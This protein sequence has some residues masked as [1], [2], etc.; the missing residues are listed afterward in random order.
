MCPL[1]KAINA[2]KNPLAALRPSGI[3]ANK[4]LPFIAVVI[5]K[6]GMMDFYQFADSLLSKE[7]T[8]T[9]SWNEEK[10]EVTIPRENSDGFDITI[11]EDSEQIYLLTNCGYH[12]H[13][14]SE[15][16]ESLEEAYETVFGLVRDL[17]SNAMRVLEKRSNDSAYCWQL[18]INENGCW[19]TESKT[20]LLFWNYFGK[21]SEV[22]FS[23]NTLPKRALCITK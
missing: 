10:S 20:S 14:H 15:M 22:V 9:Y 18:Q 12:D 16:F 5:H 8:L 1:T 17:L 13:W 6:N 21:K 19:K 7:A 4:F 2:D 3:I 11:G 23:N